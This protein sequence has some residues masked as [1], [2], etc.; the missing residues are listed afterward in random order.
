MAASSVAC[1]EPLA[2]RWRRPRYARPEMGDSLTPEQIVLVIALVFAL[3]IACQVVAPRLHVPGLLLLLPAGFLLGMAFPAL[4]LEDLLG[5][6][7]GPAVD[8][9]VAVILFQGGLELGREAGDRRDR[10]PVMMLVW[11]GATVTG[12]VAGV[13]GAVVLGF[14]TP[15]A[16]LFGTILVVSGPTVV[17]P[18]LDFVRPTPRLRSILMWEGD[19]LDPFGAL[20][21]VIVFQMVKASGAETLWDGIGQFALGLGVAAGFAIVGALIMRVGL[22]VSGNSVVLGT[23]VLFGAVIVTAGL[24]NT[25]TDNA[26]LLAALL[27]GLIAPRVARSQNKNI[28]AARPFFDTIVSLAVGVLFVSISALVPAD[29]LGRL[30]LPVLAVLAVL[31]LLVRPAMA[32]LCTRNAGLSVRERA[33]IGGVAPRGI[34]AAATA[35][36]V[37]STLVALKVPGAADLL[38]ATF[39]VIAGT[40]LVYG[41][42]AAPLARALKVRQPDS[43]P[44]AQAG[45]S[46]DAV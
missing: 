10:M 2:Q 42:G 5:S 26:G 12:V 14:P 38:P 6:A 19:L 30:I 44:D 24:A 36:S 31:V 32:F 33:F 34:V 27:M 9:V 39:L 29:A 8:L 1:A 16:A 22:L 18:L 13:L 45:A 46:A 28:D 23:Q 17:G 15:I 40:A 7:F 25:V 20:A 3:A 37:T 11:V 4:N 21:A 35:A 41:L 43:P